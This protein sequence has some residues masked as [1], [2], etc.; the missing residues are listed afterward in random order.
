MKP[1][2]RFGLIFILGIVLLAG[3]FLLNRQ[4]A[5][6][7]SQTLTWHKVV[8]PPGTLTADSDTIILLQDYGAYRLYHV[9]AA[10]LTSLSANQ[11][12]QLTYADEMDWLLFDAYPFNTQTDS[13]TLPPSLST[14]QVEGEALQLVQFVGPIKAE[15]LSELEAI[16]VIPIHY[17]ANNGYLVWADNDGR[18]QLDRLVRASDFLQFSLPHQPYFKLGP[19]LLERLETPANPDEMI[20]VTIQIYDHPAN[21]GT[22]ALVRNLAAEV[23]SPWSSVL[24]FLNSTVLL[25]AGDIEM[26]ANRPDVVWVGEWFERELTDEVQGQIIAGN[27]NGTQSGPSAPGYLAWL[28]SYGFSTD[29]ADYPIV[30]IVDDGIGNGLVNSGDRTLHELGNIANPTRLAY[31]SNCTTAGSG[32]GVGGHGHINVSIAGGYDTTAGFPF[33]D[34]NG[35]QRGLGISPYGRFAGT[36]IFAPT[37]NLTNCGGTDTGLIQSSQDDGALITSNSWGC[38][39]CS[40]TYDAS[41]QAFDVGVRDADLGEAGNQEMIMIFAAGNDGAGAGTIGTPGNGKNMI[42]VG[43]SENDRPSDENGAWTDGCGVTPGGANNAMDVIGFSSR[44]PAPGGRVKPEVIAPGTHIQGTASTSASYNGTSVCDQFRPPGQ[45]TFASSSGTSH[46]TPAVAGV[47]SLYYWWLQNQYGITPS[48]ALMKAY[49]IAHPTYLTGVSA[50][51]TLPSNDQGYGMP[52][53]TVA[54]DDAERVFE[55]QTTL[56]DNSGETWTWAGAVVDPARPVRIVMTYSDQAGAIGTTPQ[57]ND[58]NLAAEVGGTAYLGNVFSGQWSI[59]GGTADTANNYEAIFLPLGTTGDITI[60]VTAFNIAG[61]GVPNVG[62]ATDQ[63]FAL[64][65]YNCSPNPDFNVD[66]APPTQAVCA[67]DD[68]LYTVDVTQINGFNS[69]VTLSTPTLPPGLSSSFSANNNPPPFTSDLTIGN[70]G[71][72]AAGNYNIDVIGSTLT[73]THTA[74]VSLEINDAIPGLAALT[75]PANGATA[76]SLTPTFSWTAAPQTISYTLDVAT[77]VAFTNIVYTAVENSTS[78]TLS[79]PLNP[80]TTYY[81]RIQAE[82]LCGSGS[83]SATFSFTTI[84]LSVLL[85]DDDDNIPDVQSTYTSALNNL[86]ITYDVWDTGNSDNEPSAVQLAAYHTV[87]WFSGDEFGGFAGPGAAGEAALSTWLDTDKCLFINSQD[88][89]Y[90]RGLT[91]FM[92]S[93]LGVATAVSDVGQTTVTGAGSL[94]TGF[95]PYALSYPFLNWSDTINP[96]GPPTELAFSGNNGN[97]AVD[98]DTGGYKTSFWGFPWEAIP[99]AADREATLQTILD[100]CL[101]ASSAAIWDGGGATNDWSEAANWVGDVVPGATDSVLFNTTST[102]DALIDGGFAGT[103]AG[104]DVSTGYTGTITMNRTFAVTG[105]Y[106]QQDGIFVVSDPGTFVMTVGGTMTHTGGTLRQ[107]RTV[108]AS[109]VPFLQIDDGSATVKYRGVTL[110]TGDNLGA[111]TVNVRAVDRVTQFC[112]DTGASSPDY[113]GRCFNITPTTMGTALVRLYALTTELPGGGFMPAVYHD[114]TGAGNW[115]PQLVSAATGTIGPYTFA[116]ADTTGFSPFL[117]GDLT[118]TPTAVSLTDLTTSDQQSPSLIVL[119]TGLLFLLA[120]SV[121]IRRRSA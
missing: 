102:K 21:N 53:M 113:A 79:T 56:F 72:V 62:D 12:A 52:N 110:T 47:S 118:N 41:S 116:E 9:T 23:W 14:S 87:I 50:N 93:Y 107:T 45:T 26:I 70:T 42:T 84:A 119:I 32:E 13:L 101:P 64:V 48:P 5:V 117:I 81:W 16:D 18:E 120:G 73:R 61:D 35:Y 85:V 88:Y 2:L 75:A 3:L 59:T 38:G 54:F 20:P 83:Y 60:T 27:L 34:P 25:R 4:T 100:W 96:D 78:H 7:A 57:V 49:L 46:S 43:A 99:T 58:L 37:F 94:F 98:K 108:N 104:I 63:D 67:P 97:A 121:W 40:G 76:V 106:A 95:G 105:D 36:R 92:D 109:S 28:N 69:A 111:V 65:C 8:A 90:D 6:H 30:D 80:V 33:R 22:Q 55:N 91:A 74:T 17:I 10:A 103:V 89:H 77:D 68:A 66:V 15:W 19:S 1:V 115:V 112:T 29:P 11:Q 71:A 51:D 44:G 82:N 114:T 39:G 86:G 24:S 31:I